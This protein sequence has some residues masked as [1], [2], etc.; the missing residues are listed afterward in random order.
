MKLLLVDDQS[1][2]LDGIAALLEPQDDLKVVGRCTNGFDGLELIKAERPH[3]A[4]LD[5][6]MPGM[7]GI[8]L[9]RAVRKQVPG[10]DVIL[11]SMYGHRDFVLEVMQAGAKG[12]LLKSVD[13]HEL[14]L[15]LRTV[16]NGGTYLTAELRGSVDFAVLNNPDPKDRFGALSKREVQVVKLILDEKTNQEIASAL[17]ISTDTVESH[18]KNIMYKLDVRNTAGLVKY[19][20][21]R[22]WDK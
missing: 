21:E 22:G 10:T 9:T 8:E 17:F 20:M 7:D 11:L 6:N 13:K 3:I 16:A 15:A 19:A 12:Y 5:I 14:L 1:I 4:L 2:I 18:R